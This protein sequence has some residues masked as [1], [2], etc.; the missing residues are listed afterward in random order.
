MAA[1]SGEGLVRRRVAEQHAPD[2]DG[3]GLRVALLARC[4][5]SRRARAVATLSRLICVSGECRVLRIVAAVA[6]PV[7]VA[8]VRADRNT[9]RGPQEDG[10]HFIR[11]PGIVRIER[12]NLRHIAAWVTSRGTLRRDRRL[13]TAELI[14]WRPL[15]AA[16]FVGALMSRRRKIVI[17]LLAVVL[18]LVSAARRA[19]VPGRGLRQ[20]S[21]RSARRLRRT[22]ER[23]R[24]PS[25]ARCVQHRR[26]EIVK[27]G[28]SRPIPFFRTRSTQSLGG[29]AQP[30]AR[31]DRF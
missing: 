30:V 24:H 23:H 9:G 17:A 7:G 6:R 25:L 16:S 8:G 3:L 4:R 28:A 11:T 1:S 27:T 21:A 14:T 5:S 20:R 18:L 19:A 15:C 22:R 29:V 10:K 12:R 13:I 26:I 31:L 2:H